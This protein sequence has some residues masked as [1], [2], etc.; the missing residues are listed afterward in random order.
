MASNITAV[1]IEL[2][3]LISSLDTTYSEDCLFLNIWTKPQSG[4]AKKAIMVYFHGGGY[5]GGTSSMPVYN[6]A[7]LV[8]KQDVIVVT[9]KYFPPLLPY[10][11]NQY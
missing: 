4:E 8:E 6:G 3:N 7:A 10:Y 9:F 1:G 11:K 5:T 2:F